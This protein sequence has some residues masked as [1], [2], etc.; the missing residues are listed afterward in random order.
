[1]KKIFALFSM[2]MILLAASLTSCGNSKVDASYKAAVTWDK[3]AEKEPYG[4]KS[5]EL[6]KK[7]VKALSELGEEDRVKLVEKLKK[8][9]LDFCAKVAKIDVQKAKQIAESLGNATAEGANKI[10]D[11]L[12][13]SIEN[14]DTEKFD[15]AVK[16]LGNTADSALNE[17]LGILESLGKS[18]E[19]E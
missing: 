8:A 11:T 10:L 4:K 17:T 6:F 9:K 13:K 15:R 16:D 5:V 14:F 18:K 12:Q 1:M 2:I 19:E 3:E 7:Y